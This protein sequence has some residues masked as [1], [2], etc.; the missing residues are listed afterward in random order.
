MGKYTLTC[1]VK[2]SRSLFL[3][4]VPVTA[5][6]ADLKQLVRQHGELDPNAH[7]LDMVLWKVCQESLTHGN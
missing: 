1:Y 4:P 5:D 3:V 2:G 6:V 7:V